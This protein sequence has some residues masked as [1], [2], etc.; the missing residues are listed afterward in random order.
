MPRITSRLDRDWVQ[1]LERDVLALGSV[2][3][4][5]LVVG[6]GLVGPFWDLVVPLVA[7]AAL[8]MVGRRWLRDVDLYVARALV[9]AVLVTRHYADVLFGLF[10]VVILAFLV[11]AALDL[12]GSR[13]EVK[14][15]A[16]V[17]VA[18]GGLGYVL[19]L[20]FD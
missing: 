2:V 12:G 5:V 14:R 3:F 18:A 13:R 15:G 6:R 4:Y 16:A 9:L 19:A 11:F 1:R 7:I 20:P 8:F 17:G 10:A